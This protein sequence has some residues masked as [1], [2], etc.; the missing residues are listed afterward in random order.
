MVKMSMDNDDDG[1][2]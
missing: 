2:P 1:S